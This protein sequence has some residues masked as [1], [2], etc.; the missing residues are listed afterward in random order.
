[1][2]LTFLAI[3]LTVQA[4]AETQMM[5][6]DSFPC[7]GCQVSSPGLILEHLDAQLTDLRT[8]QRNNIKSAVTSVMRNAPKK[9]TEGQKDQ[10]HQQIRKAI[11]KH[12]DPR[13]IKRL[14]AVR[15]RGGRDGLD[16]IIQK[17]AIKQ[18]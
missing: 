4:Q 6:S 10:M 18:Q 17:S 9:L 7:A 5:F 11:T 13:Q 16:Q 15:R 1:M 14:Q 3:S 12:L 2:L 8:A